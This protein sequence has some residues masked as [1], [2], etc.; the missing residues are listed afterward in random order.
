MLPTPIS[1]A[2]QSDAERALYDA[3]RASLDDDFVVFHGVAWQ[4]VDAGGRPRDGE[5][6]FVIAHP[7]RGLLVVEVKGGAIAWDPRSGAWTSVSRGGR[8]N[9]IHNPFEQAKD[10]KYALRDHLSRVA[11]SLGRCM[12]GHAVAF[13]DVVVGNGLLGPDKPR[14]IVL[15][16]TDLADVRQ[17]VLGALAHWSCSPLG[18]EGM[19]ALMRLLANPRQL[20]PALW[21]EIALWQRQLITLTQQQFGVLNMLNRR[22]RAAICGC[23]GSGKTLIAAEK[24]T[25]L[26]AS[27]MQ[28][29]LTCYNKRL[30]AELQVKLAGCTNLTVLT[31]HDL[32]AKLAE[33]AGVLPKATD[34]QVFFDVQLPEAMMHAADALGPRFDAIV[35]DEGQDFADD[36]WVPLQMTL[37]DP[38]DGILYI[39]YDDN[40]KLYARSR[41]LPI[42]DA[43]FELSAN[44][45]STRRIHQQVMR[46]YQGQ[47]QPSSAGPE[48]VAPEVILCEGKRPFTQD[49][50]RVLD[51]LINDEHVP[52]E[53]ITILAGARLDWLMKHANAI[54]PRL[55]DQL[56]R[57]NDG[58]SVCCSTVAGFKGLESPVVILTNVDP[59]WLHDWTVDLPKLL[60][61]ACSRASAHL[62]V[63]LGKDRGDASVHQ[64]FAA[65]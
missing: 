27:G 28:V 46:F 30:A 9:A 62:I 48:G 3:L 18:R 33:E 29:L 23:A 24:A 5:A 16:Q 6:D 54:R 39:F 47:V 21:G 36:W 19:E 58:R 59:S 35:V 25:R 43:P 11:P 41:R 34:E 22:R 55:S 50:Q 1:P 31:F 37:R 38:D 56:P 61:V 45:R 4:G 32:C 8:V 51:R 40:Q 10:S 64:A 12:L 42:S 49:L 20:R 53:H 57:Q 7:Q 52:P 13:P 15:D 26:A 2:T 44:C 60:Y 17:W 14:Q 65:A 63:L